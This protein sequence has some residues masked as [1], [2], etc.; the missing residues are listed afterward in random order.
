MLVIT[1]QEKELF[2]GIPKVLKKDGSGKVDTKAMALIAAKRL[3]PTTVL[4][5]PD[6]KRATVPHNG[7]V[8]AL[9][10]AEYARRNFK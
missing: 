5:K 2:E 10:I 8:D 4:T 6:S 9:L 3:F 7:I 1:P